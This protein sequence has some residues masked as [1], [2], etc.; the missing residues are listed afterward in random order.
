M[1]AQL[2]R[3][4]ACWSLLLWHMHA[5]SVSD[6]SVARQGLWTP[7]LSA[8]CPRDVC[9]HAALLPTLAHSRQDLFKASK[10]GALLLTEAHLHVPTLV[11]DD[12][13]PAGRLQSE[14]ACP[15]ACCMQAAAL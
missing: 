1:H 6:Q 14:A 2:V 4:Q 5:R 13:L 12:A 3:M 7:A 8:D 15:A 9:E 11:H 10:A